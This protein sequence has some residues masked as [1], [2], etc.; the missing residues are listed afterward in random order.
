MTLLAEG[1]GRGG[2]YIHDVPLFGRGGA[3]HC[4]K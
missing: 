1:G 4:L 3:G 2:R